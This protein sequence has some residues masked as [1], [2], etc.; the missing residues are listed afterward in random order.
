MTRSRPADVFF[1]A[2]PRTLS[3]LL[4]RL[5]SEQTGWKEKG[6]YLHDAYQYM[7]LNLSSCDT[8]FP[9]ES[10]KTYLEMMRV[11]HKELLAARE[12]AHENGLAF[13]TKSHIVELMNPSL[14]FAGLQ[15]DACPSTV[16]VELE[17][18]LSPASR[19]NPTLLSDE[20][21]LSFVP[22][23][24]IRHPALVVDSYY[25][26]KG[27][28][29]AAALRRSL[30]FSYSVGVQLTRALFDWY[31]AAAASSS[32]SATAASTDMLLGSKGYPIVVD[33]DDLL[34]GDTVQRLARTIGMDPAQILQQWETQSTDIMDP[35]GR[36]YVKGLWESTGIDRT[37]SA[38]GL[39]L[40]A[41]FKSWNELYGVEVGKTLADL[42]N[43]QMEGYLWLKSRKF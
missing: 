28:P 8:E 19:T 40:E 2:S 23:F 29:P 7:Q 33:A 34:Q 11:G 6:Y 30:L 43:N 25:R 4:V 14:L 32:A 36:P 42:T 41:K 35:P 38:K 18:L 16:G 27:H 37:K 21:L 13:F 24:L 26:V 1:F 31:M 22:L 5:L 17:T 9:T 12:N 20:T 39:D 3:N 10:F 15:S